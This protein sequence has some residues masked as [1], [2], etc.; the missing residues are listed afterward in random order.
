M[1]LALV[2]LTGVSLAAGPL[3]R[4][5]KYKYP[6]RET[7][8]SSPTVIVFCSVLLNDTGLLKIET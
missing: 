8:T 2:P 4:S 5:L 1:P 6:V 3:H 7:S